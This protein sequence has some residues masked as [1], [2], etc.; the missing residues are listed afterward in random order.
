MY[1]GIGT[2]IGDNM[3]PGSIHYGIEP[4]A[5]ILA[6]VVAK[7]GLKYGT[8]YGGVTT[9]SNPH[10]ILFLN[11]VETTVSFSFAI[12]VT[13]EKRYSVLDYLMVIV[14]DG[15][16]RFPLRAPTSVEGEERV[17][18]EIKLIRDVLSS[19]VMDRL[20]QGDQSWV[21]RIE[22]FNAEYERLENQSYDLSR[23][24]HP[25][26]ATIRQKRRALDLTWMDD[27]RRILAGQESKP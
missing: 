27:V 5:D 1:L 21:V 3:H 19:G 2:L 23:E 6:D 11:E 15:V 16:R 18:Q 14:P 13:P 8:G 22:E 20:L 24:G 17:V 12:A 25:E 9:L 7:Y 26:A 4:Y 10:C